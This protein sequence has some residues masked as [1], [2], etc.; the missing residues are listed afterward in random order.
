MTMIAPPLPRVKFD[1]RRVSVPE[2]FGRGILPD[3]SR[4]ARRGPS[5]ADLAFEAGRSIA[6]DCEGP[7]EPPAQYTPA[8][9]SAFLAGLAEGAAIAHEREVGHLNDLA[10][11][12]EAD[13]V[14]ESGIPCW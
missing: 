11:Q 1:S 12:A 2:S 5:A 8:E 13:A 10:M 14:I 7:A 4:L 6:L 3:V 9:R